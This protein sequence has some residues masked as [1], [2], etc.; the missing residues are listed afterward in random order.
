M[1]SNIE[2]LSK[3]EVLNLSH[4]VIDDNGFSVLCQNLSKIPILES[5]SIKSIEI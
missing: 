3:L 5:L 1:C 2:E 4:N